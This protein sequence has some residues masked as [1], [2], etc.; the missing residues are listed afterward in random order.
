MGHAATQRPQRIQSVGSKRR[1]S[2]APNASNP[3]FCF[4]TG[5]SSVV[6][7]TPL[8]GPPP[9]SEAGGERLARR[10]GM[11]VQEFDT[12]TLHGRRE[13]DLLLIEVPV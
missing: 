3:L 13:S 8:I 9:L 4:K 7:A 12:L 5:S 6:T 1:A 10:D 2:S 11:G